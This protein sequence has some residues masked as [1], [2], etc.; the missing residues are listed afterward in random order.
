MTSRDLAYRADIDGLRA[1][2]VLS[3]V[4]FHAFP[5]GVRGGF[6]GV[7]VFFVISGF[8]IST[9]IF[10]GL[11]S[12]RFSV[13]TFYRRR[14]QRIFPSLLLVLWATLALGWCV[15]LVGEY[16]QLGRHV[17]A[18]AGFVSNF[19]LWREA[20][21]FDASAEQKPLLHLWSL[22]IEEQ[23]YLLWPITLLLAWRVRRRVGIVLALTAA[24]SFALAT[25]GADDAVATFY[26]PLT[27]IW[28][29][30]VGGLLGYWMLARRGAAMVDD[31][32][33]ANAL[34]VIGAA[35]LL[36]GLLHTH[37]GLP[38]PGI[39]ALPPV[40]GAAALIAAGPQAMVNRHI[41]AQPIAV[42]FGLI[43]Y[44]LY[45]WHWPLLAF[46]NVLAGESPPRNWRAASVL[47]SIGLAWASYKFVES[48]LRK[49]TRPATAVTLTVLLAM[50]AAAGLGIGQ[51]DG[52]PS[53]SV[54]MRNAAQP[55]SVFE[56]AAHWEGW[57][58]CGIVAAPRPT[59][60]GCWVRV[61]DAPIDVVV[62]G[63]SHAGHLGAGLAE[64][65]R[66]RGVTIAVMFHAGCFAFLP[67][68]VDGGRRFDCPGNLIARALQD[69]V[70][71]PSVRTIVLT[72]Y[73]AL[74]IQRQRFHDVATIPPADVQRFA[75]EFESAFRATLDSLLPSGK[76]VVFVEDVPE[77][78]RNPRSCIN[79]L[80]TAACEIDVPV[81]RYRERNALVL[82]IVDRM[83]VDYPAVTFASAADALCGDGLC[84]GFA[85]AT[86]LYATRDHLTPAG[87]RRVV[88]A[89]ADAIVP[90]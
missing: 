15:L 90:P 44:P 2:A 66:E 69:A 40:L 38:F 14:I 71:R 78:L 49:S 33:A 51:L 19:Q 82:G 54:A 61:A 89:L 41:L 8:L 1:V 83:R 22:G 72:G 74:Q 42:W 63:D 53:R 86:L 12:G 18:G 46:G 87:S 60:G 77:L 13:A 55:E 10:Q 88:R 31:H 27:R 28:E 20:G 57:Q 34:S 6:I 24:A 76:R 80:R 32:R 25:S 43:S 75:T 29:L 7:D 65:S 48:R 84:R 62:I 36:F 56:Y 5:R 85:D 39:W 45:L 37:P 17:A 81:A 64:L 67:R 52:L 50:T 47:A 30:V 79:R 21:Y 4:A 9:I 73:P 3:V 58:P 23:F 70:T 16:T 35:L 11:E 68:E 59:D 26:S